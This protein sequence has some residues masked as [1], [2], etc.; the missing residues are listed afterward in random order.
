MLDL[1][2]KPLCSFKAK[3]I[4]RGHLQRDDRI[5]ILQDVDVSV[6]RVIHFR[7]FDP[8]PQKLP[9]LAYLLLSKGAQL[10]MSSHRYLPNSRA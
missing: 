4:F 9:Q 3:V 1:Q 5:P 8:T 6:K 2:R 10:T 7:E